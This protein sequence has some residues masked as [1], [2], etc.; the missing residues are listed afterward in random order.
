MIVW[1]TL[2]LLKKAPSS[3]R[4]RHSSFPS[5]FNYQGATDGIQSSQ[6]LI[7]VNCIH[8]PKTHN[9]Q[10]YFLIHNLLC[11]SFR[12]MHS[13]SGSQIGRGKEEAV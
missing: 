2:S 11:D 13:H 3:P 4:A 10:R 6:D 8:A 1:C 7:A 5:P 12:L 9:Q